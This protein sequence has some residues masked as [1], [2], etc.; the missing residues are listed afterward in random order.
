[1]QRTLAGNKEKPRVVSSGLVLYLSDLFFAVAVISAR[2]P[3]LRFAGLGHS[4][5]PP[6][7]I[8]S[9]TGAAAAAVAAGS[10]Q[11]TRAIEAND[12]FWVRPACQGGRQRQQMF[13]F[14]NS[15]KR[16][17]RPGTH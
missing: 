5:A 2:L 4:E 14:A 16:S 9:I 11:R 3:T 6:T 17:E 13:F 15:L 8:P 12:V 1:M 10:C 7:H